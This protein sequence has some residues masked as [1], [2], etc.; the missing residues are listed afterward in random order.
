MVLLTGK[1][2]GEERGGGEQFYLNLQRKSGVL[3]PLSLPEFAG[4]KCASLCLS[5][6]V[7]LGK[8][9]DISPPWVSVASAGQDFCDTATKESSAQR[10]SYRNKNTFLWV[11]LLTSYMCIAF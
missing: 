3:C 9:E 7:S 11:T 8:C 1:T 4:D 2:G 5:V 10:Q 6:C